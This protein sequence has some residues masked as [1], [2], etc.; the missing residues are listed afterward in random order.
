MKK[1]GIWTVLLWLCTLSTFAQNNK[2]IAVSGRVIEN[3]EA[4]EP[5]EL[6]AVQLLSL[7]DSTQAAGVTTSK[8]GYFTL[9]KVKAGKYLLKV[10]FIGYITQTIPLQLVD[11][12]PNK[13]MGNITLKSDAVLLDEAVITAEAPPVTVKADTTEYNASAY[14]VA[15]GAMLEELV[16]KI[17]GAEVDKDGKITL[18][19]KEIKKIMVDGKEFFSDDPKVSM[20]NLPAN[21]IE[22]VKAYDKKSDMARFTGIDDGDEEPVLDL[23][24]KKGMK[25][26]WIGNLIAGYGSQ[27]R[28]EA[29]AMINR[30]KDDAS[31][32]VIGSSNNTNNKGFSEF[33]DAG[34][35]LGGN[36]GSGVTTAQSLGVN[37]AKN[38]KKVEVGGNVQYGYSDNNAIRKS[39]TETFLGDDQSTFGQSENDSRRKRHDVRAD[40]RL[41]WRPDTLTTIIFRPSASY[42]KTDAFSSSLSATQNNDHNPVNDR[43]SSSTSTNDN[44]SLNG[45]LQIF[46]RLNNKGRNLSLGANFGYSDGQGDSYSDSWTIFYEKNDSVS[47]IDRYTDR[48]ND[49]RNWSVSASYTEP[50]FKNHFLQLR[51]EFS[52]RKQMSQSL[53]YDSINIYPDYLE[54]GYDSE[55]ST[56]VENFYDT[57][58]AD[59]SLRGI[60]PKLMYSA[61]VGLTPQSSLSNSPIGPKSNKESLTQ[62]VMNWAPSVM[63]RYMFTKQHVLMFRYRGRSNTPNI[64]D[65]QTVIDVTDPMNLR[66]GNPNLKPS[67]NNNFSLFYNKFIPESMRSYAMN[68]FYSSTM[69]SVA[70]KVR[71]DASTGARISEKVNVNGNWNTSGYFSFNTPFKN[72]KYTLSTNTNARYSDGVSYTSI[73]TDRDAEQVLSTTHNLALSQRVTGSYRTDPFDVSLNGSVNYNLTRN[74]KQDKSNRETF[75]YYIGG[76]TNINLPWRFFLSTDL[77]CRIK[78]GYTEGLNANELLWNAQ[79]SKNVLKNSAG[80]IRFK[81]YDILQQQ[82]NLSRSI[83]DTQVSDTEYNTLGSYFMVHFVYRF[84]T[85]GGKAPGGRRGGESMRRSGH[86]GGG[87]G[88]YRMH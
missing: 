59:L 36:A 34:Q 68:V 19:G 11:N 84:N 15:E 51:Y 47:E 85:L 22:K 39:S 63:F 69:N 72:K 46:R 58:S 79:I 7:P 74:N 5:V 31:F 18:N 33:G 45:R 87:S 52:H 27:D 88:M 65:L 10:S 14:R 13:K 81:I 4:K 25:K 70:N 29:G 49:N 55:L 48:S 71:Y 66:Y 38:T 9:P 43:K 86:G 40:F 8:Q 12:A 61:G 17:P 62:N 35:G 16:K 67:F 54:R 23:T 83:S 60:H 44:Y 6:A 37:F 2:V 73:G 57:H 28:Y 56:R 3:D 50:A 42:S 20:K 76:N 30:F 75:D 77:N 26:G 53:V 80:T 82:S 41:E 32:S 78:S 24:V 1:L 64:E 21:M